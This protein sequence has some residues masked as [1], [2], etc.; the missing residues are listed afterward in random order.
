MS[1]NDAVLEE[2][3]AGKPLIAGMFER[4]RVLLLHSTGARSGQPRVTPLA[5]FLIDGDIVIM[6]SAAGAPSNPDWYHN[7][8]AYP[9][10]T[11]ERWDGDT[12]VSA[13]MTAVDT[14]GA[15]RDRLWARALQIAPGIADYQ[16]KTERVIP[17]IRLLP[18]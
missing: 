2:F 11:I 14:E 7:L 6:A 12:I 1:W 15:D 18:R 3:R 10:V 16:R 17:L 5:M 4:D 13:D 8:L 9:Q